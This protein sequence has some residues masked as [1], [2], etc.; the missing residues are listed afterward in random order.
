MSLTEALLWYGLAWIGFGAGHSL[1]SGETLKK[2]FGAWYRVAFNTIAILHILAVYALGRW[3][4]EAAPALDWPRGSGMLLWALHMTGWGLMVYALTGYDLGRLGGLSQVAAARRGENAPDDEPLRRDSL[5]RYVRHP[6][7]AAGFLI[8]WGG[9]HD[10]MHLATAF[11][12]S[13][14]LIIGSGFEERRLL[15]LYG[16]PYAAYRRRVPAF[17]PWKGRAWSTE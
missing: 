17:L 11:W 13:A 2:P 16:E 7:Y 4:F 1:L 9:V 14:Y 8:L 3:L 5:H 12:G 6:L 10:W 15:R